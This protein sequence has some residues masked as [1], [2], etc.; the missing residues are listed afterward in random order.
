MLTGGLPSTSLQ[1]K[2]T[3]PSYRHNTTLVALYA[4]CILRL[5]PS[6]TLLASACL[7]LKVLL[8]VLGLASRAQEPVRCSAWPRGSVAW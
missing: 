8:G 5:A 6:L 1:H 3:Q 4:S 7:A 2:H